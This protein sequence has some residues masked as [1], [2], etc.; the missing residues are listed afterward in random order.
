MGCG[1]DS[2]AI[3]EWSRLLM[4]GRHWIIGQGGNPLTYWWLYL[5]VTLALVLF[6]VGWNLLGDGLNMVLNPRTRTHFTMS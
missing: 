5:P 2:T 1:L 4:L 6:G 3:P